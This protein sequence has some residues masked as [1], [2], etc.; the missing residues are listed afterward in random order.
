MLCGWERT[1]LRVA[2]KGPD[3]RAQM[4]SAVPRPRDLGQRTGL[5]YNVGVVVM[6]PAPSGG[7]EEIRWCVPSADE[8][9]AWAPERGNA[10]PSH[11]ARECP[12]QGASDSGVWPPQLIPAHPALCVW[13][14]EG[15][16][17]EFVAKNG[18]LCSAQTIHLRNERIHGVRPPPPPRSATPGVPQVSACTSHQA[19]CERCRRPVVPAVPLEAGLRVW[20]LF[21]GSTGLCPSASHYFRRTKGNNLGGSVRGWTERTCLSVKAAVGGRPEGD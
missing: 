9:T 6:V 5:L 16:V 10:A 19:F 21:W 18:E 3:A 12:S 17:S 20:E 4:L 13:L 1:P 2:A 7:E 15:A 8:S 11:V 14:V